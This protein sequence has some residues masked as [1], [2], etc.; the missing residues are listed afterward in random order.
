VTRRRLPEPS[1]RAHTAIWILL[2][3]GCRTG[4]RLEDQ[5]PHV[6]PFTA[7]ELRPAP[8]SADDDAAASKRIEALAE[9]AKP[10][11]G[12]SATL[13]GEAFP[14]VPGSERDHAWIYMDHGLD[15]SPA[16]RQLGHRAY[17]TEVQ[18]R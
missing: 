4:P 17:S 16:L 6:I 9:I 3:A 12:F 18:D 8:G 13:R 7:T 14:P 15:R 2:L 11:Y 10:D 1:R 5:P